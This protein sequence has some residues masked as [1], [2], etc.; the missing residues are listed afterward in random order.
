MGWVEE[1]NTEYVITEDE[2]REF[3]SK[4]NGFP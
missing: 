2:I 3:Q 4:V 1:D